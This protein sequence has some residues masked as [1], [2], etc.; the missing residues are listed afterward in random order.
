MHENWQE[1][2]AGLSAPLKELRSGAPDAMKSFSALARA[3]LAPNAL[4]TKT[5][6][7]IALAIA[8][9]TFAVTTK[10]R[11]VRRQQHQASD[12]ALTKCFQGCFVAPMGLNVPVRLDG[13]EV[14]N[15]DL[16]YRFGGLGALLGDLGHGSSFAK[17]AA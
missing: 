6:E 9:D 2:Q 7:L 12:D 16:A 8:V 10:L 11:V 1:Y 4:D 14:H 13:A 17:C 5:K 3:A 15:A